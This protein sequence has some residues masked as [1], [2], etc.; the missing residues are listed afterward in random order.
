MHELKPLMLPKLVAARK[1]SQ[2]SLNMSAEPTS[3]IYSNTDS[4]FWSTSS[5][6]STPPTPSKRSRGHFRFPSSTST[7]SSSPPTHEAIEP[8]NSSGKLPKLT[9]EPVEREFDYGSEEPYRCSCDSSFDH[10]RECYVSR[11]YDPEDGYDGYSTISHDTEMRLA[12]R[13][14]SIEAS[15]HSIAGKFE[16]RFPSF[17]RKVRDRNSNLSRVSRSATPSRVPST[18]SSSMASS[19]HHPS[20]VDLSESFTSAPAS[21]EELNDNLP[22]PMAID[23]GKANAY[24][25]DP[26]QIEA[27]RYATTPLLPP[28]MVNCRN[29]APTSSPLQSPAVADASQSVAATPVDTPLVRG[30]LTPPLSSKPSVASFKGPRAGYMV[31]SSDIPPMMLADP[32]DKWAN[33]LGHANFTILPEPYVPEICHAQSVRQLLDDWQQARNN[34]AKHQVRTA[35]HYGA[36][37]KYYLLTERKWAEIDAEWKKN[38]DLAKSHAVAIGQELEPTSPMEPEP[39]SKMPTLNDPKSQGKFPKLGDEDIVG[40]MFQFKESPLFQKPPSKKRAF[41]KFLSDLKFP[42]SLLGRSSTGVRGY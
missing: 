12:K 8:P 10:M 22:T 13:R 21:R 17:S 41:F 39:L 34:Y 42:G 27:E 1:S 14:R 18:R 15:A 3:S 11:A 16:R 37:S 20:A 26:K 23:V 5:E 33:A 36:T 40:P 2:T 38:H 32:N 9:E 24:E 35:E 28:L 25:I 7:L 30:Y 29:E 4:G 31:P 6:C 19:Q